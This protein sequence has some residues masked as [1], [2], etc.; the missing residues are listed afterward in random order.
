MGG[1]APEQHDVAGSEL[2]W[3][4][5]GRVVGQ[6]GQPAGALENDVER[7][8]GDVAEAQPPWRMRLGVRRD[9]AADPHG[10]QDICEDVHRFTI[11]VSVGE[12]RG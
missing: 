11:A 6:R 5:P 10:G 12:T 8:A 3:F 2:D 1:A 9:R 7:G 4:E